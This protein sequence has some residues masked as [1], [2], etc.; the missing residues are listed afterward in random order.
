MGRVVGTKL[1]A[2]AFSIF[3]IIATYTSLFGVVGNT[4]FS[5]SE[6]AGTP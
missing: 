5:A 6:L 1:R 4:H 2:A 3:S